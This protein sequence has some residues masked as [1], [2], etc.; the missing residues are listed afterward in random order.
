VS[1]LAGL[2]LRAEGGA[3]LIPVKVTPRGSSDAVLGVAEGALRLRLTAPPVEGAANA[4]AREYLAELLGV[5]RRAVELARGQ[6]A[7]S[8]LFRVEGLDPGAVRARLGSAL[9]ARP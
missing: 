2:D 1:D 6:S 3:C 9:R 8:K 7:R 4:A 5:P